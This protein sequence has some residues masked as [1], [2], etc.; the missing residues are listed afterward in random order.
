[1]VL[2]ERKEK[3]LL[4]FITAFPFEK[5]LLQLRKIIRWQGTLCESL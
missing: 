1:V 2:E 4:E 3:N 5:H